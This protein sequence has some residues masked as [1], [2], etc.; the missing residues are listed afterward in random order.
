MMK[1]SD[2][3]TDMMVDLKEVE[4]TVYKGHTQFLIQVHSR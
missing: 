4:D 3:D 2:F 1:W